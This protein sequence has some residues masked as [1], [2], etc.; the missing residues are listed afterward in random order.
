MA[1]LK[2]EIRRLLLL[3]PLI[4]ILFLVLLFIMQ[5][6]LLYF[7]P[8]GLSAAAEKN[9]AFFQPTTVTAEDGVSVTGYFYPPAAGRP[10]M[11]LFHGNASHPAWE[12][13]KTNRM[14]EQGY[15][16]LLAGYRGYLGNPGKPSEVGFYADGEAY[17]K[18]LK[19]TYPD[20][21][22]ILYGESLG[23][24][25][26]VE[27]AMR[28]KPAALVLEVPFKSALSVAQRLY[29]YVPFINLMMLDPYRNDLK[30][31]QV[32]APVLFLLAGE[33]DVVT[34]EAG[35]ELFS[36]ANE[37]KYKVLFP[38]AHHSDIYASGAEAELMKFLDGV[39]KK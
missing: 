33:D 26:A 15:G 35:E 22:L 2:R 5:R 12:A 10:I 38:N 29:W 37:S 1:P 18:W 25:V 8:L 32:H 14:R 34:A 19:Q 16:V 11:V 27:M 30:I 4:F 24:G 21:P 17:L 13:F 7:P 3:F 9:L 20:N 39:F 6:S 36:L 23:S 31:S 28:H